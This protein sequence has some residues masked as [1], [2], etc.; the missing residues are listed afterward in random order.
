MQ[1]SAQIDYTRAA[2][3]RAARAMP[4][5]PTAGQK[6]PTGGIAHIL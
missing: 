4:N 2:L 3:N 1:P 5:V 6:L